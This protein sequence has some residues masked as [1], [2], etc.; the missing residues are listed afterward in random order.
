MVTSVTGSVNFTVLNGNI[1]YPIN[2]GV[3]TTFPWLATM[4]A[5]WEQYKFHSL[6]FEYLSRASTSTAGSFT[7]GPDY[8][9]GDFAPVSEQVLSTYTNC[10]QNAPWVPSIR[11][12]LGPVNMLAGMSRKYTRN[13]NS[14]VQISSSDIKNYD[15]GTLY[16]ATSDGTATPWGKLWVE[17]DVEFFVPQ[18]PNT[19][20]LVAA[21]QHLT[22]SNIS[23]GAP[24]NTMVTAGGSSLLFSSTGN[25]T[26]LQCLVPGRYQLNFQW[27]PSTSASYVSTT[28]QGGAT[29][30]GGTWGAPSFAGSGTSAFMANYIV[31]FP[32]GGQIGLTLTVVG[33]CSAI[34]MIT[35]ISPNQS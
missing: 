22:F 9:A 25:G 1:G 2:P 23:S 16:A 7:M 14:N 21:S 15:S 34:C 13:A 28:I 32:L 19:G 12:R 31:D 27:L 20:L 6:T 4:A 3:S 10:V 29:A 33:T 8:D 5:G 30:V 11:C 26:F 24:L 18:S 17:Y 35:A